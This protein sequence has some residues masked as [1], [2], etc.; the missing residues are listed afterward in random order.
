MSGNTDALDEYAAAADYYDYVQ[1]YAERADVAFWVDAAREC[2]NS[3]GARQPVLELGCGTGRVLLPTARAGVEITGLDRSRKMLGVLGQRLAQEPPEVRQ[4]VRLV[5]GDMRRFDLGQQ[6]ALVMVPFRPFQ[7]LTTVE[8][9]MAC[10]ATIRKHLR[11]DGRLIFDLFNP[12]LPALVDESRAEE[13][14]P[15]PEVVLPDG[16]RFYRT[17]RRTGIDLFNQVQQVEM[18]YYVTHPDGRR[19]R[20]VHA[21]PMRWMFRYEAE[22]LL[23]RCGFEVEALYAD[24]DKS[25]YGSKYP[26]DLIFVAKRR[27]E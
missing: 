11:P 12:S 22:H 17:W 8:D 20:A 2:A 25:S 9:Q 14:A 5:E 10:L 4:R 15:E 16:R 27:H 6:F 13:Q 18:Y 21:F 23:A 7:H 3:V 24:Y 19:E 26:G 1:V